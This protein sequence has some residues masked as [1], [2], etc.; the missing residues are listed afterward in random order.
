MNQMTQP[1]EKTVPRSHKRGGW[2]TGRPVFLRGSQRSSPRTRRPAS[3]TRTTSPTQHSSGWNGRT[4]QQTP[5]ED[6]GDLLGRLVRQER[7]EEAEGCFWAH[8]QGGTEPVITRPPGAASLPF[9]KPRVHCPW[10][11]GCSPK[12]R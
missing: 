7:K 6:Q 9:F 11:E 12:H 8:R 2:E 4:V 3:G 5:P 1:Q 10:R